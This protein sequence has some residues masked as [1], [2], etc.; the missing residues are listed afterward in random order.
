MLLKHDGRDKDLLLVENWVGMDEDDIDI[1][2]AQQLLRA[3]HRLRVARELHF[4]PPPKT[5]HSFVG[6]IG[7][8]EDIETQVDVTCFQLQAAL[9]EHMALE[10]KDKNL[11]WPRR[12]N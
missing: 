7:G 11:P 6:Q 8:R 3:K 5:R 10:R 2:Y 1:H 4:P 9:V 12:C